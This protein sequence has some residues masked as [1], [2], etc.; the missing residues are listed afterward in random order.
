MRSFSPLV[1]T[2]L[3]GDASRTPRVTSTGDGLPIPHGSRCR[4]S[5]SSFSV[6]SDSAT[7]MSTRSSGTRSSGASTERA[8]SLKHCANAWTLLRAIVTPAAL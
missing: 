2:T 6:T 8:L 4:S 5:D 1:P 3:G 7:S